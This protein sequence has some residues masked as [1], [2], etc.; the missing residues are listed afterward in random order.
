MTSPVTDDI[1]SRQDAHEVADFDREVVARSQEIP[2][3]VDFWA[4]WCGPCRMLAPAIEAAV[5]KFEGQVELRK[6]NTDVHPDWAQRYGVRGIPSV[7]LFD[8]GRVADE[9][10]GAQPQSVVERW[11]RNALPEPGADVVE[12]ID[13]LLRQNCVDEARAVMER[14]AAAPDAPAAVVIRLAREVLLEDPERAG[15]LLEGF[16]D[17]DAHRNEVADLR[18]I[19]EFAT[20]ADRDK[21][22][23]ESP[24]REPYLE[25]ARLLRSGDV[26]AALGKL[27]AA[28][29]ADRAFEDDGARKCLVCLFDWLGPEH[30]L[31]REYRLKLYDLLS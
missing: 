15:A 19:I 10:T 3:L 22:L 9:F 31:T 25:A 7:K 23:P 6:V 14:V 17:D 20:L 24:A 8:K 26:R 18:R 1:E 27:L 30:P 13:A 4:P 11:L 5:G 16:S 21:Q 29:A 28:V 2:V 12:Q